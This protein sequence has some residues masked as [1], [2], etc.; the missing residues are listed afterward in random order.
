M[1][2]APWALYFSGADPKGGGG[3]GG[4]DFSSKRGGPATYSGAI[5]IAN[6]QKG[7]PAAPLDLALFLQDLI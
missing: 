6:K 5:C 2:S 4:A 1:I 7:G 3:G